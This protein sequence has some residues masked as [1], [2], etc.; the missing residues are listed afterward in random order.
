VS[1]AKWPA[2]KAIT[3]EALERAPAER[4]AFLA[5]ACGGDEDLRAEVES[6]LAAER[7]AGGFLR[8][9]ALEEGGAAAVREAAEQ[10]SR[11]ALGPQVGAYRVV[12]ELGQGGMGV[13]YLAERADEAYEKRVAIKLVR[14]AGLAGGAML[15]RFR[16]ERN[17]LASLEHPNI[18]RLLDGGATAD[19]VPYLVMEYVEGVP[20]DAYAAGRPLAERL[21]LFASVCGAVQYAHQR[22]VIHRDLK[23][24]N[25]LVTAD[26]TAKL[27]DF[28]IAR[29]AEPGPDDDRT[30]TGLRALSF[31][32]ASPEQVRGERLAVTSDVYALGVLLY[33]L[34]TGRS[35]YAG[36]GEDK[37]RAI[38]EHMPPRPSAAADVHDRRALEGDLDWITMKAIRKEPDRR[39]QSVEQLADDLRRHAAGLPVSAGPDSWSYRAR[40]LVARRRGTAAAG[41]L[42]AGSVAAG[43]SATLWQA[44]R[45]DEQR[46]RAERR[47]ADVRKL[48]NSILFEHEAAIRDL[49]GSTPAR[50]LL[51]RHA[52]RYL[53]GLAEE[54]SD[55]RALRRELAVAY[56]KV[57]GVQGD[58]DQPNIGDSA[59]AMASYR[60]ALAILD[61]LSAEDPVDRGLRRDVA[62]CHMDIGTLEWTAGSGRAAAMRHY[63]AALEIREGLA[64]GDTADV[65]AT[66]ALVK[67]HRLLGDLE[68]VVETAS[69]F[70][71][72]VELSAALFER[73]PRDRVVRDA[74][75][76]AEERAAVF[77]TAQGD[78]A[79]ALQRHS[80]VLAVREAL[81]A[82][83]PANVTTLRALGASRFQIGSVLQAAG[84]TAGAVRSFSEMRRIYEA[85]AAADPLDAYAPAALA[86]AHMASGRALVEGGDAEAAHASFQAAHAIASKQSAGD[87]G[88]LRVRYTLAVVE[89]GL[90]D[91]LLLRAA[92]GSPAARG[93]DRREACGW[94][95]RSVERF[96]G[97]RAADNLFLRDEAATV[98]AVRR[99]LAACGS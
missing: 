36:A 90:G 85:L 17:I 81:L 45:A 49:P 25:I 12:R 70:Q 84:D 80:R 94:F 67:S 75:A 69:H 26:G 76:A 20:V 11:A 99:A 58:P 98:D 7:S 3:A 47:F 77:M 43:L 30:H 1:A 74:F 59:G 57:G 92:R 68:D 2:V 88:N 22:L 40:K 97:I 61:G 86:T 64:A 21:R 18:T 42:I 82:E 23:A 31:E 19:G 38:C 93:R 79:G 54:A 66:L 9:S 65:G 10:A 89:K 37:V 95:R 16:E 28:G 78:L 46:A 35:A 87:P 62:D 24:S 39:Y 33:R 83:D 73:Y 6:L 71:R 53:D 51:V 34:L 56:R 32:A 55:D 5:G 96:D 52:L 50:A 4:A 91:A 29:L 15:Q 60:K 63:R 41:V 44:R 8:G 27:L 14:G 48:A 13:V 72:A